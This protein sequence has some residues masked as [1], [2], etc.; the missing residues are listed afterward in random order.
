LNQPHEEFLNESKQQVLAMAADS[1][2]QSVTRDW[3]TRVGEYK[4][5]YNFTWMGRPAIQFPTDAWA[6][7]E[8]M[9]EAKPDVI[10]ETGVAH[11]GSL[12]FYAAMLAMLDLSEYLSEETAEE[13]RPRR[14]VIGVDIEI[15]EHNRRAIDG[16]PFRPWIALIEGSSTEAPVIE[17]VREESNKYTRRMVVLDSNHTHDHVF[18]ELNAYAPLVTPDQYLVVFD[19]LVEFIPGP[20]VRER[21]WGPGNN[22]MTAVREFLKQ[23]DQFSIDEHIHNKL[24]ITVAPNGFLKR[25]RA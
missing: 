2:L 10:V 16:H 22:P 25:L 13:F 6:M 21:P 3:L 24:Q 11:G 18:A 15:R 8:I 14:K 9:W 4:W 20:S 1:E 7:Q 17:R 12:V 5:A 19:T 23:S